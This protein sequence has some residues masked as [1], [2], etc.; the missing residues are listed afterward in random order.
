MRSVEKDVK[1]LMFQGDGLG[2]AV[3]I[4][5]KV[6]EKRINPSHTVHQSSDF[7]K[8]VKIDFKEIQIT[9]NATG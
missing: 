4:P 2:I 8:V 9:N 7:I 3:N 1:G 5:K 6:V